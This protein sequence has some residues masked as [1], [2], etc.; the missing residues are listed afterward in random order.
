MNLPTDTQSRHPLE[1]RTV[2]EVMTRRLL[3]ITAE[4]SM[5][6]AWEV[7]RRGRY[8]H[9]PVVTDDGHLIGVLD[10]ET[11]AS[12][13][14][15]G[16]DRNRRPV[17][18]LLRERWCVSVKATDPVTTAARIMTHHE[19]DVVSV[20]DSSGRLIGLVTARGLLA[21][22]AGEQQRNPEASPT[23]PS[24]YR[25]EPVLPPERHSADKPAPSTMPP[26]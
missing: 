1:D 23:T 18:S 5:L 9:V 7:M 10:T 8:H 6:M 17:R 21:A 26:D 4:D 3:T 11:L 13:W 2:A 24:L 25:I 20:T 22:L 14:E 16:P 15:E 12:Q 19:I